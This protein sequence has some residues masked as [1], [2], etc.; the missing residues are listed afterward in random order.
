M[1]TPFRYD[2]SVKMG[3]FFK[4]PGILGGDRTTQTCGLDIL[5]V[6]DRAPVFSGESFL[7]HTITMRG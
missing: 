2:F 7:V 1:H 5:V 4:I 3:Y 6:G